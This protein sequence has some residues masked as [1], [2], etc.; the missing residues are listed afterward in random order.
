MRS[1]DFYPEPPEAVE[2]VESHVSW[3]FLA[4]ERAYKLRKPVVFPFLDYGSAE[5]RRHMC[6]EEVRLGRRLAPHVYIGVRPLVETAEGWALGEPGSEGA[7]HVVEMR[8]FDERR[9]LAA[10]IREHASNEEMMSA[11]ARRVAAFHDAAEP[12]P[13]GSFDPE[14]VAATV[15]ENFSTLLPY[16]PLLG[17][18]ALGAAHRFAVAFIHAHD[19]LLERRT[20][21][22]FVRDCHGDLRAEHVILEDDG[23]EVFDPVEFDPALREID[24]SADLAFL[25][26]DLIDAGTEALAQVLVDEYEAAGG[27]HGGRPLLFFY[28]AY[29]AWVRA[30]VACVRAGE[31]PPG[32]ARTEPLS[33]ARRFAELARRLAWRAR[34]PLVIVVCGA[35]ATGKTHLAQAICALSGLP[36]L[37]SD[38]VRKQSVGLAPQERAPV[39][40]YSEEASLSTYREL[41]ARA[42]AHATSGAIVD[43]TFRR[44]SHRAA[45]GEAFDG[46]A[47]FVECRAP[48]TVVAERA[49][50][51]EADPGR[52]SDA[53]P[54][55]AAAQLAEFDP[56]DEVAPERHL[57]LRTDRP[58]DDVL[59]ELEAALDA[60]LERLSWPAT[61]ESPTLRRRA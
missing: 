1:P 55:I 41:G 42:A 38:V 40:Q 28:A 27:D 17:R 21:D 45:F 46:P 36:H 18:R 2:V 57:G 39:E 7:E 32:S 5:R 25:L 44:R 35:S 12:A 3:V 52:V 10:L 26:M 23:V 20:E 6:E 50:S 54:A 31:L 48:A 33:E 53:T 56:L 22:G 37:S 13:P 11:V 47:L 60:R 34:R 58:R 14:A 43:A 15:S 61:F 9:T 49:A 29:R 4:G 59:A 16:A 19:G 30:K 8:R 24:V 51:R